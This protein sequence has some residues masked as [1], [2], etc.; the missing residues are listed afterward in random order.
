MKTNG[1]TEDAS[2]EAAGVAAFGNDADA[3]LGAKVLREQIGRIIEDDGVSRARIAAAVG[4]SGATVT[5]FLQGKYASDDLRV[6][7]KITAWLRTRELKVSMPL[8]EFVPTS[9]SR[10]ITWVCNRAMAAGVLGLVIGPSGIGKDMGVY[11]FRRRVGGERVRIIECDGASIGRYGILREMAGALDVPYTRRRDYGS[12]DIR[13][14][15]VAKLSA[16]RGAGGA[17]LLLV[18]NETHLLDYSAVEMIRRVLDKSGTGGV[19]VGTARLATQMA[20]RGQLMYEQLRRRCRA[21]A[22]FRQIDEVPLEDVKAVAESVAGRKL[23]KTVLGQLYGEA[24]SQEP[25]H[26]GKL[27]RVAAL[28]HQAM[29]LA[30]DKDLCVADL[31]NAATLLAA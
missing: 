24:N 19:L 18:F 11:D 4:V 2:R 20:G 30:G 26:L 23:S 7:Q 8:P 25:G 1:A 15:I 31:D 6:R 9:I 27:G 28:V 29:E 16:S 21:A 10:R 12:Q 3:A 13:D 17:G 14:A 22:A 5:Q